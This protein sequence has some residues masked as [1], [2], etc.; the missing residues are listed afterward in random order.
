MEFTIRS[1][2]PG[3]EEYVADAHCR[4]YSEEYRWNDIFTGYAVH[5]VREFAQKEKSPREEMWIAEADGRPI[6]SIM[7]CETGDGET[8]QLRL[9]L[10]EKA[11]RR[12]GVGRALTQAL[13]AKAREVGYKRLIL[14]TASCLTDAIRMYERL[15]FRK[16]A[17]LPNTDWSLDGDVVY[18][19]RMSMSLV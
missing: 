18:E 4:I 15:G 16:D 13:M 8:G 6:G 7:L 12:F 5:I 1:F 2:R 19:V 10:V 3:D 17:E 11:Y 9:F 14:Q